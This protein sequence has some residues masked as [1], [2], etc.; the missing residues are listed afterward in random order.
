[1]P[2]QPYAPP[3]DDDLPP[4]PP[5]YNHRRTRR[6]TN[7][8]HRSRSITVNESRIASH[9]VMATTN[10]I[11]LAINHLVTSMHYVSL[12]LQPQIANDGEQFHHLVSESTQNLSMAT[13]LFH[14]AGMLCELVR[15][16]IYFSVQNVDPDSILTMKPKRF[17]RIIELDDE[18][19]YFL[20]GFNV[21]QLDLLMLHLRMPAFFPVK[22]RTRFAG[23]EVL[24][25]LFCWMRKGWTFL[26]MAS[27]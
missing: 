15:Q 20:T 23:E 21:S 12:L 7:Y 10:T 5:G 13:V 8:C 17:R 1:M 6:K 25:I 3:D 19:A 4:P 26:E 22:K 9:L 18:T 11:I 14:H 2:R 24:I 27:L 16:T